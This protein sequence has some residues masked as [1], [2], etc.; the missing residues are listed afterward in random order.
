MHHIKY[1]N[2]SDQNSLDVETM[3]DKYL[4]INH[5]DNAQDLPLPLQKKSA[6]LE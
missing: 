6:F 1:K 3:S 2:I 5:P 4:Q